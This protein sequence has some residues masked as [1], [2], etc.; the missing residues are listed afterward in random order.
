MPASG[1]EQGSRC[2]GLS[3]LGW[4]WVWFLCL[5][6]GVLLYDQAWI[7]ESLET[8]TPGAWPCPIAITEIWAQV[9]VTPL[10]DCVLFGKHLS[11]L[12]LI[13]VK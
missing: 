11:T 8:A 10:R 7:L 6:K 4:S 1:E 13:S 12:S 3:T 2:E 5:T 9:M